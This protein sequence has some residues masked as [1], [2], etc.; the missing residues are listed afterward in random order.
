MI[1]CYVGVRPLSFADAPEELFQREILGIFTGPLERFLELLG[2]LVGPH[3]FASYRAELAI[4]KKKTLSSS[5]S[6]PSR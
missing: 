1:A 4:R 3:C 6:P 5:V 2:E